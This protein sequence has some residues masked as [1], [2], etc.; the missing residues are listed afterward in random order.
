MKGGGTVDVADRLVDSLNEIE[1]LAF[2]RDARTENE[3]ER[4]YGIVRLTGENTAVW[5]DDVMVE[6]AFGLAVN[7]FVKDERAE[8]L[9]QIQ[10]KLEAADLFYRFTV[11]N[12]HVETDAVEW[13]WTATHY[14]PLLADDGEAGA[15]G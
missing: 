14:G 4:N 6:Q 9:S 2:V 7:V 3:P 8:W 12:Y 5:A 1:G 10:A 11:R 13:E 15:D